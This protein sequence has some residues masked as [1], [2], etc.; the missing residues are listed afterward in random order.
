MHTQ[1]H[2]SPPSELASSLPLSPLLSDTAGHGECTCCGSQLVRQRVACIHYASVCQ[3]FRDLHLS[4]SRCVLCEL[5]VWECHSFFIVVELIAYLCSVSFEAA[6]AQDAEGYKSTLVHRTLL[7]TSSSS[8]DS[9]AAA[10]AFASASQQ[11]RKLPIYAI[12]VGEKWFPGP[13]SILFLAVLPWMFTLCQVI[14]Q[15]NN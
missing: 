15:A 10:F 13:L 4:V 6:A 3:L 12:V 11:L 2:L 14:N 5:C 7:L 1:S 8:S 9:A